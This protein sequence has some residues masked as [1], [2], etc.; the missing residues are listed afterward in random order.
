M[1]AFIPTRRK[2]A[3][4]RLLLSFGLALAAPLVV[5]CDIAPVSG[6][7]GGEDPAQAKDGGGDGI[8]DGGERDG[9]AR[10]AGGEG[11]GRDG[12][13]GSDAGPLDDAAVPDDAGAL[14][15]A[16][17][18]ADAGSVD[19]GAPPDAGADED[20]GT[21]D[22]AGGGADGGATDGGDGED[23]AVPDDAGGDPSD[24]GGGDPSD[25]AGGDP[26][27]D[28]GGEPR[29]DA[30][31]DPSGDGGTGDGGQ[32][33]GILETCFPE[34]FDPTLPG[35]DYDQ[36]AP[37]VG[38]HCAGTDHQDIDGVE[39]VVFIG[40]SITVGSPPTLPGAFYR[41][42]LAD[43]LAAHF[44]IDPPQFAWRYHTLSGGAFIEESGAFAH[45]AKWGAQTDDLAGQLEDCFPEDARAETT[46]VVLTIGGND[47]AQVAKHGATAPFADNLAEVQAY[48]DR[49]RAAIEWLKEPGRFPNGVYVVFANTYEFTDGTADLESCPATNLGD[50]ISFADFENWP[51][52]EPLKELMVWANEEYMRIAVDTGSDM[53]FLFEQFCGHGFH[54]DDPASPCY[55]GPGTQRWFDGTCIHPNPRGHSR[56]ADLFL[57]T[58]V[59]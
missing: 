58:I 11:T 17:D 34:I 15:D 7:D 42:I 50:F 9:G 52:P 4:P 20:A 57:Q 21:L 40:D 51:D 3:W 14:E 2:A 36:F 28:A 19:S 23:A 47:L 31:G 48:V 56:V 6:D 59:E 33:P 1:P 37:L 5:G 12:G 26:S 45:C 30:G 24:A 35:P 25:D 38:P 54:A 46:L 22:D 29:D 49:L 55:R 53:L 32:E 43:D 8:A 13:A 27:D 41:T 18:L 44:G 39:R 10:D 16:G